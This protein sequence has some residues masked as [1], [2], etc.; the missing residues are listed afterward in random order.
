MAIS[1]EPTNQQKHDL[2]CC[3]AT[4]RTQQ[5]RPVLFQAVLGGFA[6]TVAMTMMMY[7][8][9]PMMLGHP[10]DIAKMLGSMLGGNWWAGMVMHFMTG[11][12]IFPLVYAFVLYGLLPGGPAVKGISWGIVLWLLAQVVVMPMMGAGFFS[13]SLMAAMG[14]LV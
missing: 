8:V 3:E 10:M 1:T 9:A 13:G 11:T 14:S 4:A 5:A 12:V 6:G 7:F 2:S